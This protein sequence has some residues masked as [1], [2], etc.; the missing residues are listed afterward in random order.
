MEYD[1]PYRILNTSISYKSIRHI[2]IELFLLGFKPRK[3][4]QLKG[5]LLV[6]KRILCFA[7]NV[8][9]SLLI[10]NKHHRTITSRNFANAKPNLYLFDAP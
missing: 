8:K 6:F 10:I 1:V 4:R 7:S 5:K 2:K 3:K 9:V